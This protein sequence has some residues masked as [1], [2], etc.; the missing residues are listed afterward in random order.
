MDSSGAGQSPTWI[1]L[2]GRTLAATV[3]VLAGGGLCTLALARP[4]G[5]AEGEGAGKTQLHW[6]KVPPTSQAPGYSITATEVTVSQFRRCV[7]AGACAPA[8][9]EATTE[10]PCNFSSPTRGE[11]PMNCVAWTGADAFCHYAGAHL[12]TESQWFS[13]CRGPAGT[14]YPYGPAFDVSACNARVRRDL[15][16]GVYTEPVATRKTCQGGLTGLADMTG[17]VSEWLDSCQGDYCHFF[18]GAYLDNDPIADFASCK[19]VCAGNQK[20]FRSAMVGFRCC[21]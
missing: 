3:L 14:D 20:K 16:P 13:A 19:R 15:P 8:D 10:V 21:R 9:Y 12:C 4:R 18:G 1:S 17:N 2:R 6:L 11:H 7:A 5:R